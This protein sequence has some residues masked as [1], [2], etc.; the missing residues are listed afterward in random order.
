[1]PF[2]VPKTATRTALL[3]APDFQNS[4][5]SYWTGTQFRQL[6][7]GACFKIGCF[8][9]WRNGSTR[10]AQFSLYPPFSLSWAE[11]V[12]LP[13]S[14]LSLLSSR[15]HHTAEDSCLVT[16][17]AK[18][19]H[20]QQQPHQTRQLENFYFLCVFWKPPEIL[21]EWN[22]PWVRARSV[23]E[24][25]SVKKGLKKG[26]PLKCLC[27]TKEWPWILT[28]MSEKLLQRTQSTKVW[29][30]KKRFYAWN[31]CFTTSSRHKMFWVYSVLL[32]LWSSH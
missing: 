23:I 17:A 14:S 16:A 31:F 9:M 25:E 29:H 1:M 21:K 3:C 7:A 22:S 6:L 8:G 2:L 4:S 5:T 24:K 19:E 28:T 12:P 10:G 11:L 18:A 20:S 13:P 27:F 26:R 30:T 32:Y 15:V